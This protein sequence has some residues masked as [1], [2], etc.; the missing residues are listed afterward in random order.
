VRLSF[1]WRPRVHTFVISK[2]LDT[3]WP[4]APAPRRTS[5]WCRARPLVPTCSV[6]VRRLSCICLHAVCGRGSLHAHAVTNSEVTCPLSSTTGHI[7]SEAY[8]RPP[9]AGL[10]SSR[11]HGIA[12]SV[13]VVL[14]VGGLA[15]LPPPVAAPLRSALLPAAT[16]RVRAAAHERSIRAL[17]PR[18]HVPEYDK[19]DCR[20]AP[21]GLDGRRWLG[22]AE[23]VNINDVLDG[24]VCWT[25]GALT[26]STSMAM[27][28]SSRWP[29]RSSPS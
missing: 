26:G 12:G 6:R 28:H 8:L 3:A 10:R 11:I 25:S 2:E 22:M 7:I 24:H 20:E 16:P 27:S 9:R 14:R 21:C 17:R 18:G 5:A 23:A 4:T 19:P 15:A 13:A 1:L 29:A